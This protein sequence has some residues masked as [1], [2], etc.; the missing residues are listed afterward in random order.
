[1]NQ[2][3][4]PAPGM[5]QEPDKDLRNSDSSKFQTKVKS[6]RS[7]TGKNRLTILERIANRWF[8]RGHY[9]TPSQAMQA[10]LEGVM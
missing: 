5:G 4:S 9:P 1:M 10:L 3:T 8:G 7:P 2:R 6:Q